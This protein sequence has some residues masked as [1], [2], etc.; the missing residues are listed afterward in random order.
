MNVG[1][2]TRIYHGRW[3][4]RKSLDWYGEIGLATLPRD[5]WGALGLFP[6][7]SEGAVWSATIRLPQNG[8]RITLNAQGA[9]NMK[10][11]IADERFNLIPAYSGTARGVPETQEGLECPVIW[12]KAS[13]SALGGQTVRLRV[14][15]KGNSSIPRLYAIYLTS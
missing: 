15:I 6:D 12:A 11:E 8:C 10:V 9:N 2:E 5:R 7:Q 4:N 14:H 3:L 1:E 13:L